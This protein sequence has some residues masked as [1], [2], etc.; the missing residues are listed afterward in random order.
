LNSR[1]F[2]VATRAL[3]ES[4]KRL[5]VCE[6]ERVRKEWENPIRAVPLAVNAPINSHRTSAL[7]NFGQESGRHHG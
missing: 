4:K 3:R 7:L 1:R 2:S 6:F 5:R